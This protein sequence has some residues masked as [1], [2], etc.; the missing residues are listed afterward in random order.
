MLGIPEFLRQA[1]AV[2]PTPRQCAWFETEF[3]GFV[4][5]GVN[6]YTGRE[7]GD[8][9]EDPAIFNPAD[10]NCDQ[11][12]EAF[13][14]A[15]MR[16]MV[17]TA[18]HHDGFCL[19][20][21][22]HTA[23]SVASSPFQGDV[24]REAAEACRRGG[25]KF[26]VYLSPW[27]RNSPLYGTDEYN[28]YYKAQLV[29]LLT[30]YG[31][32]FMVWLDGACG[33]GPNG[34][35]QE[36]D[37]AGIHELVRQHQPNA[38][39]FNGE[40]V[41]WIGNE[42]GTSRFAEWAVVPVELPAL[43][44]PLKP[45]TGPGPLAGDLS[46][47]SNTLQQQGDLATILQS[48]GLC[49]RPAEVDMSIR[50]GWFYHPGEEPHS[51]DR[52]FDTYCRSVGGNACLH[53]NVPP[54]PNG[55][56]DP[57]DVARL[58]ALGERIRKTFRADCAPQAKRD[59]EVPGPVQYLETLT[60]ESPRTVQAVVLSEPL[61]KGQRVEHF[62]MEAQDGDGAWSVCCE[63]TIIGH[64]RICRLPGLATTGLRVRVT[65]ARDAVES[66]GIAV[67]EAE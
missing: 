36:Y 61:D 3:Y 31:E 54:M 44:P 35:R 38:A 26:G 16:G 53:L 23:H 18:K 59:A 24:V 49:Y 48:K 5:F 65:A 55:K 64:K 1:A 42:A 62:L 11:W 28:D 51:L 45:L 20:P 22:K 63:G 57:R 10:L 41:R 29:E 33:E 39:I 7:W 8:G 40:D 21:S 14:S 12:V 43:A 37:W 17:L 2:R 58:K 67:F 60:W 15:G 13:R 52:L 56:L 25:L 32:L 50:P 30:G 19:W 66:L 6:T 46:Y 4:H 9:S 47:L 34:R 27:D